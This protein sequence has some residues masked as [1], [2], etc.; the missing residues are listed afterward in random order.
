MT[1]KVSTGLRNAMMVTG[2]FKSQ[3]D[4]CTLKIYSGTPPA[5]ADAA[6]SSN[7]M[8]CEVFN[9]NDGST[10]LTF[11]STASNGVLLKKATEV[12]EGTN[13]ATGTATFYRLELSADSGA[14]STTDKRV[15]GDVANVAADLNMT[16]T[17]L[18]ESAPQKIDNFSIALPTL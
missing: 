15:Q 6:L 1:V 7:T 18:V 4:S 16:S 3:M 12:W 14:L 11:E 17:A 13:A 10:P 9:G 2:S 8:L 5:T